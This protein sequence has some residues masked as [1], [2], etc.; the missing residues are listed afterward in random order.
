MAVVISDTTELMLI[1]LSFIIVLI[2]FFKL[3]S[4]K[5]SYYDNSDMNYNEALLIIGLGAIYLF[6]FYTILAVLN[7]GL[8][9]NIEYLLLAIQI[10]TILESTF[11]SILIIDCLKMYT[12]D[13]GV[14]KTKPGRSLLT[15]LIL[16][17][18]SLWMSETFSVKKYDMNT[19][20]LEYYDIIFWSIVSS[21][22][23]PLGIFFRFHASVCLSDIWK[24][25]YE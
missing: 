23:S 21:I 20:Q 9:S 18:V 10:I 7:N 1:I 15:M 13:K 8:Q 5:F 6:G 12:K 2:T 24:D 25:L 14:K 4:Q 11:Q 3:R 17:D 16:I 19:T 22:A